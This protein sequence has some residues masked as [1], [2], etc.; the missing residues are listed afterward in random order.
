MAE[1]LPNLRVLHRYRSDLPGEGPRVS[2]ELA[3]GTI[4]ARSDL[5]KLRP[6]IDLVEWINRDSP[7]TLEPTGEAA[8]GAP[9]QHVPAYLLRGVSRMPTRRL[10]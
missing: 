9:I 6:G 7:A 2:V 4:V 10:P 5:D 3:E 8:T 1:A